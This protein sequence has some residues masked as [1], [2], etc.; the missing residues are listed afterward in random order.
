MLVGQQAI[1]NV[2]IVHQHHHDQRVFWTIMMGVCE[3]GVWHDHHVQYDSHSLGPIALA[4]RDTAKSKFKDNLCALTHSTGSTDW[5]NRVTLVLSRNN[6]NTKQH[7]KGRRQNTGTRV[8][9]RATMRQS[10]RSTI[11]RVTIR[12]SSSYWPEPTNQ[13]TIHYRRSTKPD[14]LSSL[15]QASVSHNQFALGNGNGAKRE[16][17]SLTF[18]ARAL[19][20]TYWPLGHCDATTLPVMEWQIYPHQ[21][22][23][24]D[25][26]EWKIVP[27]RE[28]ENG[29]TFGLKKFH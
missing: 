8:S 13:P 15:N 9:A 21:P 26:T 20:T 24:I 6:N 2:A 1:N 18:A 5:L 11:G 28:W 17:M 27:R 10:G 7:W 29:C 16:S 25:Q 3:E 23:E 22:L 4:R 12:G 14:K 19:D